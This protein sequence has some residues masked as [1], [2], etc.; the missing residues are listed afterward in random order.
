MVLSATS[1]T[2]DASVDFTTV[3][4][5]AAKMRRADVPPYTLKRELGAG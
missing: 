3:V 1:A 2:K 4:C 5:C